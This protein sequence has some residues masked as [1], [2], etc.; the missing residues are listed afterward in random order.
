MLNIIARSSYCRFH[1]FDVLRD[2]A[3]WLVASRIC[4]LIAFVLLLLAAVLATC[5]IDVIVY[6]V[7]FLVFDGSFIMN[8]P[9]DATLAFTT[10]P[11]YATLN[12]AVVNGVRTRHVLCT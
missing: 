10:S 8:T 11:A 6:T 3:K 12:T 5:C 4:I 9:Y 1:Y 2:Y 7:E